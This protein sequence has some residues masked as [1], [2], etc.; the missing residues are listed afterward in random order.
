MHIVQFILFICGAGP[1]PYSLGRHLRIPIS[2]FAHFAMGE[3]A[4]HGLQGNG[5][6]LPWWQQCGMLRLSSATSPRRY[7]S[8]GVSLCQGVFQGVLTQPPFPD[9]LACM[10]GLQYQQRDTEQERRVV[11]LHAAG[12][13]FAAI[14]R[15]LQISRERVS[16]IYKRWAREQT[17]GTSPNGAGQIK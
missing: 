3:A 9:R 8:T 7:I 12:L 16:A 14:G 4:A 2:L 11:E 13:D 5:A 6:L 17:T 1:G 15:A 10:K